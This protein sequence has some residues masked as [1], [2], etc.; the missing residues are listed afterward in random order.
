MLKRAL[1]LWPLLLLFNAVTLY[2]VSGVQFIDV[3]LKGVGISTVVA[4]AVAEFYIYSKR[5]L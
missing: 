1:W 2:F 3:Y 5:P 4:I